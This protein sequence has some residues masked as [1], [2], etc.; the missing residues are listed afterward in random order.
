MPKPRYHLSQG[1]AVEWLRLIPT[2]SL[3]LVITD[4][5]YESL[6]KHRAV[7]TTT[8]LKKSKASSNE[9]FEV[10]PN[11]RLGNP[12]ALAMT[13]ER[14]RQAGARSGKVIKLPKGQLGLFARGPVR[15]KRKQTK[16]KAKAK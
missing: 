8:R 5:P 3:D 15:W 14:V 2:S 13:E 11:S 12:D 1:D 4:P 6:E 16:R 9:W 10:F 7:G